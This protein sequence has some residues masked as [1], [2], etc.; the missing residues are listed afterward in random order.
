MSKLFGGGGDLTEERNKKLEMK[1]MEQGVRN[2]RSQDR[3]AKLRK[4]KLGFQSLIATG[5]A[6]LDDTLG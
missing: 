1:N 6:G 4:K 5:S 2:K 3:Q